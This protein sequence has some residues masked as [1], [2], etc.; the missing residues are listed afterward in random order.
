M[1]AVGLRTSWALGWNEARRLVLHP[2]YLLGAFVIVP[3]VGAR[4]ATGADLPSARQVFVVVTGVQLIWY[5]LMSL[6]AAGLVASLARRSRAQ[7][8]LEALP[9]G[10]A[11]RT[12]AHCVAV[13]LGPALISV[14]LTIGVWLLE[15]AQD[16]PFGIYTAAE[17]AQ[18]PAVVLGGGL[19]GV[20]AARWLRW[21]G[22]LLVAFVGAVMGTGWILAQGRFGW[23]APWTTA[24]SMLDDP[25]FAGGSAG[26]H[27]V[28]LALLCAFAAVFACLPD[29]RRR[30]RLVAIGAV[31]VAGA[32]V[33]GWAQLP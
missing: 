22:G 23:L 16:E 13:L 9:T 11:A 15:R 20:A 28:Y 30:G 19:L 6:L 18:V 24:R 33:A 31:I 27:A 4:A 1:S 12:A 14:L 5:G 21:R 8:V 7:D 3:T 17:L 32:A 10:A 29:V 25:D 26:W 2:V